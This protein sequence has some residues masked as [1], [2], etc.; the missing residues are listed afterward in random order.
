[1]AKIVTHDAV[2]ARL[3]KM[4][5]DRSIREFADELRVSAM[6]LSQIYRGKRGIGKRIAKRLKLKKNP[7]VAT[8][9]EEGK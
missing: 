2:I 1:M 9:T 5:G 3:K 6:L 4:Q 7:V 8:Y